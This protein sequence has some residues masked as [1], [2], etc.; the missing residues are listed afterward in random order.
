MLLMVVDGLNS[1]SGEVIA[2]YIILAIYV[3]VVAAFIIE[4]NAADE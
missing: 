3:I 4:W 2:L 1:M